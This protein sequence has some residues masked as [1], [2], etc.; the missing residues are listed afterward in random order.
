[1]PDTET[2]RDRVSTD[3]KFL[4]LGGRK[5]FLRGLTYGPFAPNSRGEPF[6]SADQ[7]ARD[8]ALIRDLGVNV[9]RVYFVPPP[10][11]LELAD[12]QGLKLLIDVEWAKSQCFLD[13]AATREEARA[14]VRRAVQTCAG[15][16]AVFAYSVVNELP[17]DI[18]RWSGAEAVSD[19]IDELVATAKGIDPECLCTFGNYPPTEFLRPKDID[20]VC[21]NVYLHGQPAFAN[22]LARLQMLAGAKPLI[23]GESGIDSIREG[24]SGQAE[25]LGW[26]IETAF[27]AGLAG[28]MVFS[29]TDDWFTWGQQI[30]D[31]AFGITTR[32]RQ[33]K[34]AFA[35]V[36][37]QYR[38]APCFLLERFPRV[39]VV[40]A[41]FNGSRTIK[42]CL[43]SLANL[44]YP[45]Y[46]I[47]CVDDGSTDLTSAIVSRHPKVRCLRH[48]ANKGLSVA[49]NTGIAA[50][51]GEIIAF[52]D[53]DCRA[54]EDWLA[55]LVGDLTRSRFAGMGGPNLLPPED[56]CVAA[57]VMA[58]PGG[59]A[60][61][62]LTD[63]VA[64]HIPGCNM[65]FYRWALNEAGG[66]DPIFRQAGDDVDLCWRLQ[67]RG[68]Q[69]G[70]SPAG[71]VWHYR[72]S[73]VPEYLRQQRGY[74]EAEALLVHKHPEYF[75]WF[76]GCTWQGRIYSSAKLGPVFRR[77]H[78]YH[79]LFGSGL[80]QSL[81][82]AQPDLDFML[83]TSLEYHSLVTLPLWILAVP[84][85]FMLPLAITSLLVSLGVC[86]AAAAQA[87]LPHKQT[88]FWSRP[89]I[90]WLYFAQPIARGLA[91]YQGHLNLHPPPLRAHETMDSLALK[92]RRLQFTDVQY[93]SEK[94]LARLDFIALILRRLE[95]TDW[96]FR[97]DPGWSDYDVEIMGS[98][99]SRLQ[100][101]TA[102]ETFGDGKQMMRCRL[103]ASWTL[104]ARIAFA[105]ATAGELLVLSVW[106]ARYPALWLLLL[107]LAGL[108][109]WLHREK[110]DLERLIAVFLDETAETC[111][112]A[113]VPSPRAD[114][115]PDLS[116][117]ELGSKIPGRLTE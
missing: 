109:G 81:Y 67:Q 14:A 64:E 41:T 21:F 51:D 71:F 48:A 63:R 26:Q 97:A 16:P 52:L 23:L 75:N 61:V 25:I 107:S 95:Q 12:I 82:A 87:E 22:Y 77:P 113:K 94:S 11:F 89:L 29:F 31:W 46:E 53:D 45:N 116:R 103:R 91:R 93:W 54:D 65:A 112:L 30:S 115:Q 104:L 1:M 62:M 108:A 56:S 100:L 96:F 36:Q 13:S 101:R 42:T 111:G 10:W 102:L 4:R 50:T 49:R 24:Q 35:V 20:F 92:G 2:T 74:G 90:A 106:G 58:S 37:A 80:F 39:S 55:Y 17:P 117:R 9:L 105:T 28:M 79:G 3:G 72:R 32:D 59:P 85:G 7:T 78:V 99:W 57:A 40:V 110:R 76:G 38:A 60:P 19:F 27:R 33:P 69:I 86:V 88:R 44:N 47:L 70:F 6:A 8:F 84:F 66:F 83:F 5:F 34:P 18:V 114:K 98:P 68:Y 15:H 43:D 73:T